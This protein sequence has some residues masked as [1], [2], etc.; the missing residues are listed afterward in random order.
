MLWQ[1]VDRR[2]QPGASQPQLR[3]L[4]DR[5]AGLGQEYV[6]TLPFHVKSRGLGTRFGCDRL[7]QE[8]TVGVDHLEQART[9]DAHVEA[10]PTRVEPARVRLAGDR[11]CRNLP[12]IHKV[13]DDDVPAVTGDEGKPVLPIQVQPMRPG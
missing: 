8:P 13:D 5:R 7:D 6:E 12:A 3:L 2:A 9:G 4:I 11:D 10:S 1:W